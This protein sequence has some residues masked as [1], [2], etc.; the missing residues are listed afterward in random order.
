MTSSAHLDLSGIHNVNPVNMHMAV[1]ANLLPLLEAGWNSPIRS[2][3][4]N[5]MGWG[6][7]GK[8]SFLSC[9]VLILCLVHTWQFVQCWCTDF[10]IPF[11]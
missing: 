11:Q 6:G 1:S 4:M 7:D 10:F 3:A 8:C 5:S 9:C 2:I